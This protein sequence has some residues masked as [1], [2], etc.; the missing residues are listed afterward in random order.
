[1][2]ENPGVN[3]APLAGEKP[4]PVIIM[5][6][7]LASVIVTGLVLAPRTEEGKLRWLNIL[8]TTNHGE[9]LNPPVS[10]D[11]RL[12][13]SAGVDWTQSAQAPWKLV[14]VNQGDCVQI[15][16]DMADLA[17]RVH[18]RLNKVAPDLTRGYLALGSG[19]IGPV[20]SL[21]YEPLRLVDSSLLEDVI[22]SGIEV[23]PQM[24]SLLLL[25]PLGVFFLYY[26]STHDGIGML[27]DIEHV[28]DLAK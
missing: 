11:G 9:F 28:M 5:L 1:M 2:A 19:G 22:A 8:G 13:D 20:E 6:A 7:M 3:E 14:L 27:E 23:T 26:D 25:D 24:P 4:W 16:Q 17:A 12:L 10:V 15:C 21:A 18:T